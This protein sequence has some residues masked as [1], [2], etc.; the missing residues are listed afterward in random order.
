MSL[1]RPETALR[2]VLLDDVAVAAIIGA[3]LTRGAAPQPYTFPLGIFFRSKT[4]PHHHLGGPSG[5][6]EVEVE[7]QW[8]STNF[9]DVSAVVE[10]A[11]AALDGFAGEV[12][13]DGDA[14]TLDT[15]YLV[16]E[17]DGDVRIDDGSG[18]PLYCIQQT[19]K[20][21]YQTVEE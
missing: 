20:A 21:A 16:D 8:Y 11:E 19:F 9:D 4:T 18:E 10:V 17:R 12:T 3:R 14:V 7:F 5:L 1:L 15:V 2:A 13:V 6:R